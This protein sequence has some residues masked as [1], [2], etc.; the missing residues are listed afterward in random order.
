MT[1]FRTPLILCLSTVLLAVI[2]AAGCTTPTAPGTPPV[3]TV[4]ATPPLPVV[5]PQGTCQ[6]SSCHGL[7]LG[8]GVSEP[9]MCTMEYKLGDRC[10]QYARCISTGG[11]C[12]LATDPAFASCKA[13]VEQCSI[14]AGADS[15]S[16]YDCEA[17]C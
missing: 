3:P 14:R 6:F 2:I 1:S 10:R 11:T 9:Q 7:D 4:S 13:C 12:T 16:A 17:K 8:C 5:T 15:L